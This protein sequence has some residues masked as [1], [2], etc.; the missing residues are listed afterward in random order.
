MKTEAVSTKEDTMARDN[1][2]GF[3]AGFILGALVGAGAA[4]LFAPAPGEETRERLR[5]RGIEL[6]ERAEVLSDE[7]RRRAEELSERG[8]ELLE[9]RIARLEALV[10][11]AIVEGKKAAEETQQELRARLEAEKADTADTEA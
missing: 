8:R 3:W 9:E 11:E 4:F 1:G 2:D 7:A 10:E 5:E 6:R